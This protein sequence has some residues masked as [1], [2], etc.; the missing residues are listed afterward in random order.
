MVISNNDAKETEKI[1]SYCG[2]RF[3]LFLTQVG[4]PFDIT[5]LC[6]ETDFEEVYFDYKDYGIVVHNKII[7]RIIFFNSYSEFN[8]K[9][10]TFKSSQKEITNILGKPEKVIERN[11]SK[12]YFWEY[13]D[14]TIYSSVYFWY[15]PD[16]ELE[17]VTFELI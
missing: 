13:T 3:N 2:S 16:E 5:P 4:M 8:Y 6:A 12:G 9:G 1:I 7:V 17:R 11:N 15:T 10:L 14:K